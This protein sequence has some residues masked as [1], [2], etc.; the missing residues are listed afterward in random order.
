MLDIKS[1]KSKS[2][3]RPTKIR[4]GNN[5]IAKN[6]REWRMKGLVNFLRSYKKRNNSIEEYILIS[7]ATDTGKTHKYI[8]LQLNF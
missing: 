6:F 8:R 3:P 2:L 7:F 4:L 1:M 5:K